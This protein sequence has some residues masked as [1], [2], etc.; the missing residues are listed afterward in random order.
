MQKPCP[1]LALEYGIGREIEK[2]VR[3]KIAALPVPHGVSDRACLVHLG[4]IDPAV[5]ESGF[6]SAIV[7]AEDVL[8]GTV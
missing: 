3:D 5:E 7:S 4:E 8:R 6:F 2:E 1:I